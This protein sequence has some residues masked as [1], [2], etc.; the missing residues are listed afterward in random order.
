MNYKVLLDNLSGPFRVS[1]YH[2][3]TYVTEVAVPFSRSLS[4]NI[5]NTST[6]EAD[7]VPRIHYRSS[8]TWHE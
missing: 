2:S 1:K 6:Q 4:V 3:R 8:A 7:R 5:E